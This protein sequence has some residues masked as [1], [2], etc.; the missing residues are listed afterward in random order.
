MD[1]ALRRSRLIERLENIGV[2]AL[3]ATHPPNVRYLTGFTGSNGQLLVSPSGCAL[4]TDGRYGDQA[5]REAPDLRVVGYRTGFA[6]AAIE[7]A[8]RLRLD[9]LSF[10]ATLPFRQFGQLTDRADGIELIAVEGAVEALRL[11]KDPE[12][13]GVLQR[14]QELTDE[15]FDAIA[16]VLSAG[17]SEREVALELEVRM[18][19]AGADGVAF[20]PI[21]AFGEHAAE[22]HHS[23]CA[24]P[25][26][27]GDLVKVDAG[28]RVDGY[29]ADM[30]RTLA[31]GEPRGE[32]RHLYDVVRAAQ[33]AGAAA[34]GAGARAG[35]V[36]RAARAMIEEAGF[37]DR[38]THPLGHGVGLEIHE[39]PWLRADSDDE[40]QEGSVVTVEPGVYVPGVGGVRIEDMVVVTGEGSRT[41]PR[42]TKELVVL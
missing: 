17:I 38:Y 3:L 16:A 30:T 6:G 9:R 5:A 18:R 1:H 29:H 23:P 8:R 40:L 25:L 14:A 32:L 39:A 19:R 41:L 12:E 35:D 31:F 28:A 36:D 10:E 42:S 7:E 15:C 34:V 21:V 37:G 22:P 2:P 33:A 11:A 26:E 27:E 4:L 24:R 13:L 20:D